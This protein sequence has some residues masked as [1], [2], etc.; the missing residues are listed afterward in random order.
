MGLRVSDQVWAAATIAYESSNRWTAGWTEVEEYRRKKGDE[1]EQRGW[2]GW[3]GESGWK[4]REGRM[5]DEQE[6]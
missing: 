5:D 1:D 2:L 3:G 6:C 4:R